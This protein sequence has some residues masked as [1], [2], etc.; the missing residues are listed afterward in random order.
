MKKGTTSRAKALAFGALIGVRITRMPSLAK[1]SSK[2]RENL[3]S[4]SRIRNLVLAP[5]SER[6]I[7]KFRACWVTKADS[8]LLVETVTRTRRVAISRK[9][10]T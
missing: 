9:N 1:T 7:A 5:S 6:S 4:R 10:S 8:G 3:A 2:E